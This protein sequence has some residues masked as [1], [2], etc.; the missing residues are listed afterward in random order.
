[1]KLPF[2]SEKTFI[3]PPKDFCPEKKKYPQDKDYLKDKKPNILYILKHKYAYI[4]TC[5]NVKY[6]NII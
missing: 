1:M 5:K 3:L 6:L 2:Q 4:S